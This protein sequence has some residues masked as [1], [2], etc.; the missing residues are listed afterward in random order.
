VSD[1]PAMDALELERLVWTAVFA[2]VVAVFGAL[3]LAPDPTG[4]LAVGVGIAIFLVVGAAAARFSL[5][6]IPRDAVAGDRTARYLVFFAV[7]LAV[8]VALG[9]LSFGGFAGTTVAFGLAWLAAARGERL[10]PKRW[11]DGEGGPA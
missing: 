9:A 8:R 3:L 6:S 11:G 10:N 7:A 1:L 2:A 4:A 5:G